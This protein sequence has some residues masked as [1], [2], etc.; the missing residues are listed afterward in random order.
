MKTCLVISLCAGLLLLP[1]VS[2][3]QDDFGGR[4]EM[5]GGTPISEVAVSPFAAAAPP[6]V[7]TQT[8]DAISWK[9]ADGRQLAI[10]L[11][12]PTVVSG[13]TYTARWMNRVLLLEARSTRP[14]GSIFTMLQI[15]LRNANDELELLSFLPLPRSN[16]GTEVGRLVYYRRK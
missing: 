11:N 15:L 9:T 12:E 8:A 14:D 4:W 3:A 7:I 10:R 6:V 13:R 2:F 16:E 5:S 1:S